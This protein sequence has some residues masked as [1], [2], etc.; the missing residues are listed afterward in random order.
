MILVL[1]LYGV[2]ALAGG[3]MMLSF[4]PKEIN[5][6]YGYRT[7]KSRR[8][9]ETWT[10]S[11]RYA[12]NKLTFIGAA[13]LVVGGV[14]WLQGGSLTLVRGS[15]DHVWGIAIVLGASGLVVFLTERELRR[16]FR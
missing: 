16:R 14:L 10:F 15:S 11:Q 7:P 4:P 8:N 3:L 2:V 5:H 13:C 12:A 1:L 6:W 9:L